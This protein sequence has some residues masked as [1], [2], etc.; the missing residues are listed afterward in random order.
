MSSIIIAGFPGVCKSTASK[1]NRA[2]FI[3]MESSI[4]HWD[5]DENNNRVPDKNWPHNYIDAVQKNFEFFNTIECGGVKKITFICT[6]THKEVI[7]EMKGRNL[8][9][10]IVAPSINDKDFYMDTYRQRGNTREFIRKLDANFSNFLSDINNSGVP[11][12]NLN[13][14]YLEDVCRNPRNID[15][16]K[17][18]MYAKGYEILE[19]SF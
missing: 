13:G 6:S 15:F 19:E 10:F 7:E 17:G 16:M 12:F 8:P 5:F 2:D 18:Y 3:D 4:Y 11:V 1:R 9:F 14:K